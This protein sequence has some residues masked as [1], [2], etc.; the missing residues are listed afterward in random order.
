MK[1]RIPKNYQPEVWVTPELVEEYLQKYSECL[2]SKEKKIV[3]WDGEKIVFKPAQTSYTYGSRLRDYRGVDQIDRIIRAIN[4]SKEKGIESYRL[5][6]VLEYPEKDTS[7]EPEKV[8][9]PCFAL[10][11]VFPR[12]NGNTWTL[13]LFCYMRAWD[14][15]RAAPANMYGF[16]EMLRYL[17]E[18]TSCEI[19]KLIV[20]GGS[21]HIYGHEL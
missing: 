11:Q 10:F 7:D 21:V 17:A 2:L 14:F 1:N 6:G 9:P 20:C 16:S 5:Y 4:W 8:R 12:K 13:D 3:V 19:G 15:H 18:Q